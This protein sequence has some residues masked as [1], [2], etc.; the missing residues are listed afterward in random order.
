MT[1]T[2]GWDTY[3]GIPIFKHYD[4]SGYPYQSTYKGNYDLTPHGT[5]PEYMDLI[6]REVIGNTMLELALVL[7]FSAPIVALLSNEVLIVHIFGDSSKGKT[8][9]LRLAVSPF[10]KPDTS[11][12]G[13]IH[14][15]NGTENAIIA[16]L[17]GNFGIPVGFDEGSLKSGAF[18]KIIY[19][20]ASGTGRQRLNRDGEL[21]ET[22][23]WKTTIFSTA[24]HSII[25][26]SS[27]NTGIKVRVI[28]IGNRYWTSSAEN[29][30]N[31]THGLMKNY[32][33]VG[34]TFIDY[35]L[36]CKEEL[37]SRLDNLRKSLSLE[38]KIK[39]PFTD[40]IA[41]KLSL[42][43][44]TAELV[45]EALG[46]AIDVDAIRNTLLDT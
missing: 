33:S 11:H 28:E 5:I 17:G 45:K 12:E 18:T 42:I 22:G 20:L 30:V 40:R 38:P 26:E 29:S 7:G 4:A 9:A 3:E 1:V 21:K 10:V 39:S 16:N 46:L 41:Q 13:G 37:G 8:T 31:L 27:Q 43:I 34:S 14:T 23:S 25:E 2:L 35:I 36:D 6:N 24:E 32:A 19:S 15:W 44:L